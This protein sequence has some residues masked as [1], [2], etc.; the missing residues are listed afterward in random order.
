MRLDIITLF[1]EFFDSANNIGVVGRSYKNKIWDLYTWN[2]RNF[3]S[4]KRKNIDDRPYGGGPG[5]LMKVEPLENTVNHIHEE[6]KLSNLSKAPVILL[7]PVGKLFTQNLAVKLAKSDG[8]ILVCGRYEG[9]DKRFIDR[10]VTL[11]MSIGDFI[12]SGG[13]IAALAVIDSIVRLLPG[14]LNNNKSATNES[15][16]DEFSGLLEPYSYTRPENYCGDTVPKVLLSG[17]HANIDKWKR[18]QSLE[19]TCKRR[20]DLIKQAIKDGCLSQD[21]E[22]LISSIIP[23]AH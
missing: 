7:T 16:S 8:F 6:R 3:T 4:D 5:M 22:H 19:I 14:T 23:D 12:I 20:P 21:D 11:E 9:V 18:E 10:C 13:E 1:P 17:N 15:F 2:P